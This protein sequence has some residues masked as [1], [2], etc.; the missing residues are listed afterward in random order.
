M[1]VSQGS[2]GPWRTLIDRSMLPSSFLV[3]VQS[4]VLSVIW[5]SHICVSLYELVCN[6]KIM[7]SRWLSAV[8]ALLL[9]N[10]FVVFRFFG[11][12]RFIV[13]EY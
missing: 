2:E 13:S 7:L 12:S 6:M 11:F 5:K 9:F 10:I 4:E 3:M 1:V 8:F